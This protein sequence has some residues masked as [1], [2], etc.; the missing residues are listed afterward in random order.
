[1]LLP[2]KQ[3]KNKNQSRQLEWRERTK[4]NLKKRSHQSQPVTS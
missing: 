3:K 1:M 2:K 4:K